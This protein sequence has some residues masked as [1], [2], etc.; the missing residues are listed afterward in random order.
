M[1]YISD[2][3]TEIQSTLRQ[4]VTLLAVSKFHPAEKIQ[5]AYDA[6]HRSFGESRPQELKAKYDALPKDI[7]WHMIGHLQTNK[8]K[9]IAPF[10]HLIESLDSERLAAAIDREAAKCGRTIDCLL[11]IHVTDEESKSG[12][13]WSELKAFVEA[14]GFQHY[15]NIRIRG[16]MGMATFT[17]DESVVRGDFERLAACKAE[18]APYFGEEFDTLSMGM[19]DDYLVAMEYGSTEV[20]IGSTIFGEREY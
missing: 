15:P 17:D 13:E 8:I 12:W 3:I 2:K 7:K 14:G 9:Y 16:V 4:G 19:S 20:R 11:E 6:G 10:V 18:L 1:S 5:Q